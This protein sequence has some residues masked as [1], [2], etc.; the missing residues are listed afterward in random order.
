MRG[1]SVALEEVVEPTWRRSLVLARQTVVINVIYYRWLRFRELYDMEITRPRRAGALFIYGKLL[2]AE[3]WSTRAKNFCSMRTVPKGRFRLFTHRDGRRM[4]VLSQWKPSR[5]FVKF[6][7]LTWALWL[8][9]WVQSAKAFRFSQIHIFTPQLLD[10]P[11]KF[12]DPNPPVY[13]YY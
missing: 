9:L 5:D 11:H 2:Q 3:N 12:T 10:R 7:E 8:A 1:F 6:L 13:S 4:E